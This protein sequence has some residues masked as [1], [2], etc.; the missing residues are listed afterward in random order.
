[1]R[2]GKLRIVFRGLAFIGA[3]SELALKTAVAAGRQ[4]RLWDVVEGFYLSQGPE[5]GGW[6][7]E[8]LVEQVATWAGLD[9]DRLAAGREQAW[10]LREIETASA[11]AEA[12]G[13]TGTPT[14]ELGRTG[15]R[16]E[17]V[18]LRSL[19]PE[20]LIPAIDELLGS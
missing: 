4:D 13:V 9:S 17:R 10:V 18:K 5:N 20:G 7:T 3:E 11:A 6:V 1:V 2:T 19:E 12:A 8:S 14:F 15:G 16:L